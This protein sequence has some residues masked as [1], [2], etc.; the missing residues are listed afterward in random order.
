[1]K[2]KQHCMKAH[3]PTAA[4][5]CG[6]EIYFFRNLLQEF[7]YKFETRSPLYIANQSAI[8]VAKNPQHHGRM[9]HL[10]LWFYWLRDAVESSMIHVIHCPTAEMPADLLTKALGRVKVSELRPLLGLL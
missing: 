3:N 2:V 1:M 7:G 10:D 6:Q 4:V 9:K 8:S 5:S